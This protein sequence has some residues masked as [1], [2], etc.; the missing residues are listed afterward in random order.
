MGEFVVS[1]SVGGLAGTALANSIFDR[2]RELSRAGIE[3][4]SA[5]STPENSVN[6][7]ALGSIMKI[8]S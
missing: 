1:Q 2:H 5:G 4:L 3:V 7:V 8:G 6:P